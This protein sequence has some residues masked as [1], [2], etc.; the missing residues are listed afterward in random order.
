VSVG[1]PV[2]NGQNYLRECLDSLVAQT[3]SN[4]EIVICD[5]A[6]TDDTEQICLDY[7]SSDPRIRYHRNPTNLGALANYNRTFDLAS[8]KYFKWAAHDDLCSE[9]LIEKC[10]DILQSDP[11]CVLAFSSIRFVDPEGKLIRQSRPGLSVDAGAADDRVRRLLELEMTSNDI[12]W[13]VFGVIRRRTLEKTGLFPDH[14]ASD[15]TLLLKL[16]LEGTFVEVEEPLY[17]RREH[18]GTSTSIRQYSKR[19]AWYLGRNPSKKIVLPN[20]T[21]CAE[22]MRI[23]REAGFDRFDTWSLNL[24]VGRRFLGRWRFIARELGSVPGQIVDLAWPPREVDGS[25]RS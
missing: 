19:R 7:A 12:F 18:Q 21:L 6:S 8:G 11:A 15:Q 2:F 3:Y 5:N 22:H 13:S 9:T 14:V 10:V 17:S 25:S 24:K 20:L 1:V 16:A 4:L 23:V